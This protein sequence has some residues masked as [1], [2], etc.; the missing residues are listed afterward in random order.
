MAKN[1]TYAIFLTL[2]SETDEFLKSFLKWKA[3]SNSRSV[4]SL[5]KHLVK[6]DMENYLVSVEGEKISFKDLKT[7]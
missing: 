7:K 6:L 4:A 2:D 1:E 3:K 5:V